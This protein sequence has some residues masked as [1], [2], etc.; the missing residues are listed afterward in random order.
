M[1]GEHPAVGAPGELSK[2]RTDSAGRSGL[3]SRWSLGPVALR[4]L[5]LPGPRLAATHPTKIWIMVPEFFLYFFLF[6]LFLSPSHLNMNPPGESSVTTSNRRALPPVACRLTKGPGPGLKDLRVGPKLAESP[7]CFGTVPTAPRGR[8]PMLL[9]TRRGRYLTGDGT[10]VWRGPVVYL[11]GHRFGG[12]VGTG[13][14]G[15]ASRN[16]VSGALSQTFLRPPGRF[17]KRPG[18][19]EVNGHRRG[20]ARGQTTSGHTWKSSSKAP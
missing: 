6:L 11:W 14:P 13:A 18:S 4:P 20:K 16:T 3:G 2:G 9:G 5:A 15:A 8:P 17:A 19:R 12:K 10:G 7:V 1:Q